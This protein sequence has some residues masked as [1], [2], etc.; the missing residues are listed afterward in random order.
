[1]RLQK[2]GGA[3]AGGENTADDKWGVSV[4]CGI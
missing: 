4:Y 3:D 2:A 1:M